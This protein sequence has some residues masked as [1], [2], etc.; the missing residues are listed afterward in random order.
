M[1]IRIGNVG[2]DT[3]DLPRATAFWQAVTG[4]QLASSDASGNYLED[5]AKAG[6]G[7]WVQLVPEP[8]TGKNR[9]HL[10]LFAAD[11][12]AEVARIRGLGATEVRAFD[13]WTVLADPDGNQFCV[14]AA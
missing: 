5:P 8:A 10:D 11:R 2:I 9:L 7:L 13:G 1:S 12:A 14:V 3:N 6:V 4:Y